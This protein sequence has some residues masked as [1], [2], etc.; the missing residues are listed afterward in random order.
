MW[1]Q[2]SKKNEWLVKERYRDI[3]IVQP[4]NVF[5]FLSNDM[6]PDSSLSGRSVRVVS[7]LC[8]TRVWSNGSVPEDENQMQ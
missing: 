5:A 6:L 8:P 4:S 1:V 3:D 7:N 2:V